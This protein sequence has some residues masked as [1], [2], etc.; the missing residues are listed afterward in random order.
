MIILMMEGKKIKKRLKLPKDWRFYI[1]YISLELLI[2]TA[3]WWGMQ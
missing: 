3:I 2:A 1:K